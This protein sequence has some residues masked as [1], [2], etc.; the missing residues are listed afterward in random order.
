[1][2]NA[3]NICILASRASGKS[4]IV[5]LYVMARCLLFPNYSVALLS[6]DEFAVRL[7]SNI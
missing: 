2:W 4:F 1:M 3:S 6:P 5:A 7:Y